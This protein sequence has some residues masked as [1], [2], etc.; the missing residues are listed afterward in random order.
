[1][2]PFVLEKEMKTDINGCSSCPIGYERYEPFIS[3]WDGNEFIRYDYRH[4]NGEFFSCVAKT[5][6]IAREEKNKWLSGRQ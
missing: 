2:V 6:E 4:T 5:L 1:M 3:K